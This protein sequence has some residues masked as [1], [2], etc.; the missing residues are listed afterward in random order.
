MTGPRANV[1]H[2]VQGMGTGGAE[3]VVLE[4]VRAASPDFR[5]LVCA[6]NEGGPSLEAA[7]AAGAKTWVLSKGGRH[8]E[9]VS[10]L[11]RLMREERVDVV[12]GH[13]PTGAL[14][15]TFAAWWAGVP[16]R[17]R[18]EHTLRY[19]GRHSAV[20]PLLEQ[21]LNR[22]NQRILCVSDAVR[23]SHL[24]VAPARRLVV[25]ENGIGEA[26]APRPRAEVR[27]RVGESEDARVV[28]AV[29]G[30]TRQK[31]HEVLIEAL[32]RTIP[33][34]PAARLWLAGDGPRREALEALARRLGIAHAVRFLGRRP[35]VHDLLGAADLFVLSSRRE[36]LSISLL[37]AMRAGRAAL[38]T[39]VGGNPDVVLHG[40][41]GWVV[42]AEN[43]L[44]L[45][46]GLERLL[47]DGALRTRMG[48]ASL[49]RWRERF[50][51]KRMAEHTERIYRELLAARGRGAA[52]REESSGRVVA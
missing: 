41:T 21:A 18:T 14:Y 34:V 20:Y 24:A 6:L 27:A 43:A 36:G 1:M 11:A 3:S 7:Q 32:A 13:N 37:E 47:S 48:E 9:G 38:V 39:D 10:R 33:A 51:A 25:V 49:R 46:D 22:L 23:R 44:A 8:A 50:T 52:R 5:M 31:A 2:V 28:L 12:H 45:A 16:V 17:V 35:D 29:G 42:P 40:E 19:R 30:L 26:P 15:G 4:L